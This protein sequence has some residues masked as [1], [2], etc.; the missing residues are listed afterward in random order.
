[1]ITVDSW[2]ASGLEEG[3]TAMARD[4]THIYAAMYDGTTDSIVILK[5]DPS[6]MSEVDRF[7]FGEWFAGGVGQMVV[8]GGFLYAPGGGGGGGTLYKIDTS[9]MTIAG[10]YDVLCTGV[11]FA[12]GYV[13]TNNIGQNRLDKIDPSDMSFVDSYPTL[14]YTLANDGTYVYGSDGTPVIDKI[15]PSDMSLADSWDGSATY[16]SSFGFDYGAGYLFVSVGNTEGTLSKIDV[17]TMEEVDTLTFAESPTDFIYTVLYDNSAVY[18]GWANTSPAKVYK[19]D[20]DTFEESDSWAGAGGTSAVHGLAFITDLLVGLN[21]TPSEIDKVSELVV[22]Y[23]LTISVVGSGSVSKDPDQVDYLPGTPVTLEAF[24][25]AG[26]AFSEWSGD[27]TGSDN[28]K[29]ITMDGD[30]TVTATFVPLYHYTLTALAIGSGT[31]T[32]DPDKPTYDPGEVVELTAV[33]DDSWFVS[34]GGDLS[35]SDNPKNITMDG[36]KTVT[37]TF[38]KE[39]FVS[40]Y[41]G[42][43]GQNGAYALD[44]DDSYL[45]AA[46]G[47][48]TAYL[49]KISKSDMSGVASFTISDLQE[50]YSIIFDGTDVYFGHRYHIVQFPNDNARV[51]KISTDPFAV[52]DNWW[53]GSAGDMCDAG[54]KSL[55]YDNLNIYFGV[56][57]LGRSRV[58]KIL[59]SDMS[60]V[61]MWTN[62]ISDLP[63]RGPAVCHDG[64]YL[65][66]GILPLDGTPLQFTGIV[67]KIDPATM[68]TLL[69]WQGAAGEHH[70]RDVVSDGTYIYVALG[71][72]PGK[73]VKI[74]PATMTTVAVWTGVTGQNSCRA[75][76][77]AGTKL[78]AGLAISPAQVVE[79]DTDTMVTI[80]NWT[81]TSGQ[82]VVSALTPDFIYA[83][84]VTIPGKVVKLF[85]PLHVGSTR[86]FGAIIG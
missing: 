27:L 22:S 84:L 79:I 64:T 55:S 70:V 65:Y 17:S 42:A 13:F 29:V 73:V 34:W 9:D 81:G 57:Y 5:I 85:S 3:V 24:P 19:V 51:L 83:S 40:I 47:T 28:P 61:S 71:T 60:T 12:G 21:I 35:G 86:S 58:V 62:S 41:T 37:A 20:P 72:S 46:L 2:I 50:P 48:V 18:V 44:G 82:D 6:D 52:L 26:W 67:Y 30:K 43:A 31:I 36:N 69:T 80:Q 66:A 63:T 23:T 7:D 15:D 14:Y 33:P 4:A 74:N 25:A 68:T 78:Y 1:M 76:C 75:I 45:Y 8:S 32:K 56:Y 39:K 49:K 53:G 54:Y 38:S 11:T 77:L 59:K 16:G 10:S